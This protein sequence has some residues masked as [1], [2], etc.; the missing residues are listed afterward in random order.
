MPFENNSAVSCWCRPDK[1]A[2]IS[3]ALS[4]PVTK[5]PKFH[6]A[7]L[8]KPLVP[9][10]LI[11]LLKFRQ[12]YQSVNKLLSK[13]L[14]ITVSLV[15]VEVEFE[16]SRAKLE[17]FQEMTGSTY[18]SPTK[19]GTLRQVYIARRS[20]RKDG[21]PT[22][23]SRKAAHITERLTPLSESILANM[24]K[25]KEDYKK[26]VERDRNLNSVSNARQAVAPGS[27]A[28][29][30]SVGFFDNDDGGFAGFG[31]YGLSKPLEISNL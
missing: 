9:S 13:P 19:N 14:A 21:K 24:A 1:A 18:Y 25:I 30:N 26:G 23:I 12:L 22:K 4:D 17:L 8:L 31:D 27:E 28:M 10:P 15:E 5:P 7:L 6:A 2:Q 29:D 3:A 20:T 16:G 11:K